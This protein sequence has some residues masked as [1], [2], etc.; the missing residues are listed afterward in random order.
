MQRVKDEAGKSLFQ[1]VPQN[2]EAVMTGG[3]KPCFYVFG[4]ILERGNEGKE[5]VEALTRIGDGKRFGEQF[6]FLGEDAAI[7]LV[8]RNI[9][10]ETDHGEFSFVRI[11]T[12]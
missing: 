2:S 4:I 3:F 8:L 10:T 7:V 6:P 11:D 1:Q 12:V 5:F 9:D